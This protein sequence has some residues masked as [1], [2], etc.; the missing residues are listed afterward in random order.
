[1][2]V[3]DVLPDHLLVRILSLLPTKTVFDAQIVCKRWKNLWKRLSSLNYDRASHNS[4]DQFLEFMDRTMKSLDSPVLESLSLRLAPTETNYRVVLMNDLLVK[5]HLRKLDLVG[6]NP[7]RSVLAKEAFQFHTLVI[8][9]LESLSLE[10]YY[11]FPI[12]LLSL[13]AL[14]LTLVKY[15]ND[16]SLSGV[17]SSLPSLQ[18]LTLDRCISDKPITTLAIV[19]PCLKRL[20]CVR[21]PDYCHLNHVIML[22]V[23]APCLNFLSIEEYWRTVSFADRKME[24]L[25]EANV[26]V[27]FSNTEKLLRT[28]ISAKRLSLCLVTSKIPHGNVVFDQLVRLEICTC[29]REWWIL[30]ERVLL[31]S[32]K[33]RFLKLHQKNSFRIIDPHA[34]WKEPSSVPKC[35]AS[36]LETFEW[37]GYKGTHEE[38]NLASYILRNAWRLKTATINLHPEVSLMMIRPL[39]IMELLAMPKASTSC[40]LVIQ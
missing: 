25:I 19:V 13:T 22:N 12:S 14:Q 28:L 20:T 9:M 21:C 34:I 33:L 31:D 39:K 3:I 4:E 35:F 16:E 29:Q 1:M 17:L 27:T 40:Q 26:T 8:L 11:G 5:G 36:H 24:K 37:R 6:T 10:D 30:L 15:P 7:D 32:P 2:N 23:D 18:D 38:I